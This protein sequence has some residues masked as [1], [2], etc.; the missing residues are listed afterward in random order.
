[1]SIIGATKAHHVTEAADA[2]KIRLSEDE[3]AQLERLAD[4]IAVDTRGDW[5]HTME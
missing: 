1:M 3:V 2:A 5:E 4:T